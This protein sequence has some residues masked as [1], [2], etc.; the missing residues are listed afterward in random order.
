M[1]CPFLPCLV[2]KQRRKFNG[3][4]SFTMVRALDRGHSIEK[5]RSFKLKKMCEIPGRQVHSVTFESGNDGGSAD[6]K[7][8]PASQD[9]KPAGGERSLEAQRLSF[10]LSRERGPVSR[11]MDSVSVDGPPYCLLPSTP[12]DRHEAPPLP[13]PSPRDRQPSGSNHKHH[14]L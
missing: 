14:T 3:Q 2:A 13:L 9:S 10:A 11:R 8:L 6:D 1:L 4:F 12:R 7:T 5:S